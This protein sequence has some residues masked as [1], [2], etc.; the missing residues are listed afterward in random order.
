[1]EIQTSAVTSTISLASL[2]RA[3]S[4]Q[5]KVSF[6]V[7]SNDIAYAKFKNIKIVPSGS[8]GSSYSVSR[9]RALDN[10]IEQLNRMKGNNKIETPE[11]GSLNTKELNFLISEIAEEIHTKLDTA[12]SYKPSVKST[13]LMVNILL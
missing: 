9:L 3:S 11:K 7:S 13:G 10:L 6:P 1:M 4:G 5:G 12:T 8:G 2:V